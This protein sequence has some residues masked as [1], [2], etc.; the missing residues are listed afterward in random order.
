MKE[1]EPTAINQNPVPSKPPLFKCQKCQH[2]SIN[3]KEL[4]GFDED[5]FFSC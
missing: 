2:D 3:D 5:D 4:N 1:N